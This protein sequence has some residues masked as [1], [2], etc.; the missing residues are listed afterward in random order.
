MLGEH[1]PEWGQLAELWGGSSSFLHPP[2]LLQ[3]LGMA[4]ISLP[5]KPPCPALAVPS[6]VL[7]LFS[8]SPGIGQGGKQVRNAELE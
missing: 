2:A 1:P 3:P 8:T 6:K 7:S 5:I 4:G